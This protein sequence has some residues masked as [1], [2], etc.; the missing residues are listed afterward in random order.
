MRGEMVNNLSESNAALY[1]NRKF[2]TFLDL[3]LF[4]LSQQ[5][6]FHKHI[7]SWL[8]TMYAFSTQTDTVHHFQK[9]R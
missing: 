2:M 9:K 3:S 5:F 6:Q 8:R 4:F 1:I 7:S